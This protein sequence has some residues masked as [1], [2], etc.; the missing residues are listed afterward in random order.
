MRVIH[1][2][3]F[4]HGLRPGTNHDI[5]CCSCQRE[6]AEGIEPVI[7]GQDQTRSS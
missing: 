6:V 2:R 3:G 7:T 4:G 1:H 5:N